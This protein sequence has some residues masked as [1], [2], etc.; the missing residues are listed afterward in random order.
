MLQGRLWLLQLP[1]PMVRLGTMGRPSRRYRD[2]PCH[3]HALHVSLVLSRS[4]YH[5]LTA[6]LPNKS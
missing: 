3:F 4:V 2:R 5:S 1:K 6:D